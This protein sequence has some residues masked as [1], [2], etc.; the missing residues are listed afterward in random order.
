VIDITRVQGVTKRR[1]LITLFS[2]VCAAAV[3][4][5]T[6]PGRAEAGADLT[7][8]GPS[9]ANFGVAASPGLGAPI[10][11][12][13]GATTHG[14]IG[15]N[16]SGAQVLPIFTSGVFGI[17]SGTDFVGVQGICDTGR[18][19]RGQSLSGE[20]VHGESTTGAGVVGVSAQQFAVVG[21]SLGVGGSAVG[22][23]GNADHGEGLV[24]ISS[25]GIG[26]H[27][28]TTTGL[29]GRFDGAVQINGPL[30]VTG[31]KSAVV[32]HP[33]GSTR[34][35]YCLESPESFFE[36]FGRARL[37]NGRATVSLDKDF[38]AITRSEQYDVFLTE[39]GESQGLFIAGRSPRGFEVREKQGGTSSLEFS[40]RV[41]SKRKDIAGPRL[42]R[43]TLSQTAV[44]LFVPAAAESSPAG[45]PQSG[46]DNSGPDNSGPDN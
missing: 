15:S 25:N 29:A 10:I 23:Y 24:G 11:P 17:R 7:T 20:G 6:T 12:T 33:D 26:L 45:V 19:V 21:T 4:K 28:H 18:G 37:V 43:V 39:Y 16:V 36:D 40:Y 22:L 3:A 30:M 46:P 38:A 34:Q 14:V 13:L 44:P 32:P 42:E 2:A 27:G 9:T 5:L 1:G 8:I 41:V 31:A 35:L